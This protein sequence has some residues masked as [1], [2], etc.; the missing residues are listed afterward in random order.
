MRKFILFIAFAF[1]FYSCDFND[2]DDQE[3]STPLAICLDGLAISKA[4]GESYKCQNYDL[5]GM[6]SLETMN[7]TSA[8]DSWGWTDPSTGK[9]YAL[10]GLDNGLI[11]S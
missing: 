1:L 11:I 3:L 9:E 6:V 8:N 10:I 7:A 5:I 4:S 2:E